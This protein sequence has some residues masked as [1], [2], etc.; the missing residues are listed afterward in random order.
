MI[1]YTNNGSDY[2]RASIGKAVFQLLETT[3]LDEIKVTDIYKAACVGKTTYYRYFGSKSGKRE[4]MF[5]FLQQEF[6]NFEENSPTKD[7]TDECFMRFIWSIKAHI[8]LLNRK[9]CLDIF[10]RL[11][12][13][14]YGPSNNDDT[15]YVKYIGAG[16]WMGFVRA[17]IAD[18]FSETPETVQQKMQLAFLKILQKR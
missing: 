15:I 11:I 18:S 7:C 17:L 4:A 14:I 3:D 5:F 6:N 10:D 1:T 13:S 2:I 12:L 8:L 16:M 9:N